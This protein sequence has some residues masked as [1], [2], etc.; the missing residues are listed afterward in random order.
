[1]D[2]QSNLW[3]R[4]LEKADRAWN[5]TGHKQQEQLTV[6]LTKAL[7]ET[8]A[9]HTQRLVQLE[10][11]LLGRNQTLV[12]GMT[13]LAQALSKQAE[14]LSRLQEGEGQLLRLQETLNQNLTALA[15]SGTFEEAVQSLTAAIHLLTTRVVPGP[16]LPRLA[17]KP[18]A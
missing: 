4:S 5:E 7:E 6:G 15:G 16:T 12:Q 1:M 9:H 10:E 2:R 8:L 18:A 13:Q 11:K 3:S 14:S 17:Q